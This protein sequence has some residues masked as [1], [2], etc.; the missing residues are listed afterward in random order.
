MAT[1]VIS[2]IHGCY[3]EFVSI[4]E[5]IQPG[6]EDELI[7]AG[8]YIDRGNQNLEM[9]RWIEEPP[10][11]VTL[12]KGNHDVEFVES[13]KI[14][15]TIAERIET[16]PD[17]PEDMK[18]LYYAMLQIKGMKEAYFDYYGT[19]RQLIDRDVT[20]SDFDKWRDC[21]SNMSLYVKRTINGKEHIIVHAGY[22]ET[23]DKNEAEEFFLYARGREV[24]LEGGIR[25]GVI[26]AGHT[27]TVDK[28]SFPYNAGK[29]FVFH[30]EEK[31]CT[32]YDI[33]C[34][35]AYRERSPEGCLACIRLEDHEVV[36]ISRD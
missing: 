29:V 12:I 34:G 21:I 1:Y 20:L 3:D 33:D 16:D 5:K 30:N 23:G 13:I 10:A 18:V 19:I 22:K 9:L 2:D 35:C 28:E 24:C 4:L 8:D 25:D 7:L 17:D 6:E 11:N 32:I 26:I 31:N 27:P 14:M 15:D 36:Y